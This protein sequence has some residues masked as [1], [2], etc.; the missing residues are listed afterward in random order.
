MLWIVGQLTRISALL[1]RFRIEHEI[2]MNDWADRQTPKMR[3]QDLPTRQ[4]T[5]W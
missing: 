3:V 4:K 5:W 1:L 2:L